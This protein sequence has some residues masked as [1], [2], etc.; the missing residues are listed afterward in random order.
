MALTLVH[1]ATIY[2]AIGA[3]VG[4]AFL[5][6]GI[7]KIDPAARGSYAFRPL[8]LPGLTLLWPYTA[9]RWFILA[10]RRP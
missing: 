6:A 8:L 9:A 3:I 1:V 4:V 2:L 10:R 7:E 5:F